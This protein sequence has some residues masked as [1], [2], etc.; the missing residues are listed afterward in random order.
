[1]Q[2][3]YTCMA[4]CISSCTEKRL[5]TDFALKT[6]KVKTEQNHRHSSPDKAEEPCN[7]F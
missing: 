1:M 4:N 2:K 5:G 6:T 3:M 7:K